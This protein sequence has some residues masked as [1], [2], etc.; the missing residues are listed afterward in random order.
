M[1]AVLESYPRKLNVKLGKCLKFT[2]SMLLT[3]LVCNIH[4]KVLN[5]NKIFLPQ[6]HIMTK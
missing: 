3:E 2:E 1:A 4:A 6:K 5:K